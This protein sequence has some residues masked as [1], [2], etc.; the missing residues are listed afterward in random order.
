MV[1]K[2]P[3]VDC[4]VMKLEGVIVGKLMSAVKVRVV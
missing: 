4:D 1:I 2:M 3:G